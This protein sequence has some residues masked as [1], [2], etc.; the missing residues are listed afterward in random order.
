[1]DKALYFIPDIS[2]FTRF[3]NETEIEHSIHIIAELL[4]TLLDNNALGFKLAEIEG[5]ALFMY[6]TELP[7]FEQ[8][9]AQ[10]SQ[11]LE[12]FHQH[13]YQY[14]HLR[15]CDC[16]ACQTAIHLKLKFIFHYGNLNF[17]KVKKFRKPYGKDV[18]RV[19]RLLKNKIEL[20]EYV[21][22][23]KSVY[24]LYQAEVNNQ[25]EQ[26]SDT[27]DLQALYYFYK[28]LEMVKQKIVYR[29]NP[30][31]RIRLDEPTF[32]LEKTIDAPPET[33]YSLVSDWKTRPIWDKGVQRMEYINTPL[34]QVGAEHKCIL[35]GDNLNFMTIRHPNSKYLTY[36]ETTIQLRFV[37][38]YLFMMYFYKINK[39]STKLVTEV[40]LDFSLL[41][42][43]VKNR[44]TKKL[45]NKWKEKLE[46]LKQLS[47]DFSERYSVN[48]SYPK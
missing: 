35:H 32:R 24:E 22:I 45:I 41:G 44:I 25:W 12:E 19:H 20:Q 5:D 13:I 14:N 30:G 18:I 43:L 6:S 1:M 11:M 40:Y 16:G 4:E 33:I 31:P 21:L 7:S 34:N 10:V 29:Q 17:I 15:I 46:N 37:K 42:G 26:S 28:N 36:G 48:P 9:I 2:G 47:L 23:T 39:R 27:Y 8:L 3:V 38:T